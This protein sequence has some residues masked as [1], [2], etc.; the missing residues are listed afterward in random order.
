[1]LSHARNIYTFESMSLDVKKLLQGE[2]GL[3][4]CLERIMK[5]KKY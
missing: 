3:F 1:M 4:G 2:R 5:I